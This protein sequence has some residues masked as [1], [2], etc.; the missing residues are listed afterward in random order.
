MYN[1]APA[2]YDCPFCRLAVGQST[3]YSTPDDIVYQ[4]EDVFAFINAGWWPFN[5]G[6][7]LIVP[8]QHY[9]HIY[10]LPPEIGARIFALAQQV[11]IAFKVV[12]GCDGTSTRQHNEPAG[13]QEVF[14]YH[15]HV[16]P[17]YEN[18]YLYDLSFQRRNTIAEE[19]KPY[20]EKLRRYFAEQHGYPQKL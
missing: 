11:A 3:A 8:V 13:Y 20:A 4:D 10:D 17:R 12:Y 19:R 18:D 6:H 9:E 15:F 2:D 5:A 14:H 16:F 1:H 7:V